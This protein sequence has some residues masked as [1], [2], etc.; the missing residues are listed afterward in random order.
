MYNTNKNA[1]LMNNFYENF[2]KVISSGVQKRESL[3]YIRNI[4]KEKNI[5]LFFKEMFKEINIE[6]DPYFYKYKKYIQLITDKFRENFETKGGKSYRCYHTKLVTFLSKKIADKLSLDDYDKNIIILA[7]LFHDI[8][9]SYGIFKNVAESSFKEIEEKLNV[10]HEI[11]SAKKAIDILNE[12]FN[13]DI[14]DIIVESII[15]ESKQTIY[16]QV[17]HEADDMAEL[18]RMGIFRLFYYNSYCNKT[19][20]DTKEYW[21]NVNREKK[22]K[23]VNRAILGV[24]RNMMSE[25]F[26]YMDNFMESIK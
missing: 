15:D 23:K 21:L 18:G 1:I 10:K 12:D 17:M 24:A 20:L 4:N 13:K 26:E 5:D 6:Y 14:I 25:R 16:S 2:F 19:L 7:A 9:K 22:I 3:E 8:G 11:L